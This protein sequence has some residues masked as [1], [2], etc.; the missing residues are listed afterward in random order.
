M[1]REGARA[2]GCLDD[3]KASFQD[4]D[5]VVADKAPGLASMN[6]SDQDN[7]RMVPTS[8]IV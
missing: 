2:G 3:E 5:D 7:G 6:E 1:L 4:R 8:S